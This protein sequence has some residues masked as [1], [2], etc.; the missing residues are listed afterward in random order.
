MYP[1]EDYEPDWSE[2]Q[3]MTDTK[4]AGDGI[5]VQI[6]QGAMERIEMA[7]AAGLRQEISKRLDKLI[8]DEISGIVEERLAEVV[9]SLAEKTIIEYLTKPRP[10]TNT[11]GEAI[12][13]S[14][15]TIADQIPGKVEAWLSE[16]VER[17]GTRSSYR[18]NDKLT[19]LDWIVSKFVTDELNVATKKAA[20][21][22]TDQA[23]KVVAA[24]VGKFV[25]EQMIPQIE[26]NGAAR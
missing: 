16:R 17:D 7:A 2:G 10:R 14:E 20:A 19:R 23:K 1:D 9:G 15:I 21:D 26:L 22:V 3:D 13:G 4:A 8:S 5:T 11:Y 24:H 12:S 18:S 25:A 6:N